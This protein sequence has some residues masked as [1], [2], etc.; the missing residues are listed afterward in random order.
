MRGFAVFALLCSLVL[1]VKVEEHIPGHHG[2]QHGPTSRRLDE[3]TK[4]RQIDEDKAKWPLLYAAGEG[5]HPE[6]ERLLKNGAGTIHERSEDGE[7]PLHVAAIKGHK[8]TV[9]ALLKAG[10]D[11]H[12]RTNTGETRSM[13]PI[14][15]AIY[16]GQIDMVKLLLE[17]G[18]DPLARDQHSKTVL[19]M[20]HEAGQ[21]AIEKLLLQ[22]IR[23]NKGKTGHPRDSKPA[24]NH[25]ITWRAEVDGADEGHP[26]KDHRLRR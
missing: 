4:Q 2:N 25:P 17:A 11:P 12:A 7:S 18:A 9:Q 24:D 26:L 19:Q 10:A 13:T 20:A 15:W 21:T 3:D 14:M 8:S 16:H 5:D 22:K 1:C 23:E 6:V